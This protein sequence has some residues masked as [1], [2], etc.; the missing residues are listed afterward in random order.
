MTEQKV[1]IFR[2]RV[3][4]VRIQWL[5]AAFLMLGMGLIGA[6]S[7]WVAGPNI[8]GIGFCMIAAIILAGIGWTCANAHRYS[9]ELHPDR[10][11]IQSP[12]GIQDIPLGE[13]MEY[14]E[15]DEGFVVRTAHGKVRVEGI[16]FGSL[17]DCQRFAEV[18][19]RRT[20]AGVASKKVS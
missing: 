13:V 8:L 14:W 7:I 15:G 11:V 17:K 4:L 10:M 5:I 19:E 12:A 9:V 16:C 20:G 6:S 18:L 1:V 3:R 2:P